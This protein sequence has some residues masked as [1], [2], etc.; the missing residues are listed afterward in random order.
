MDLGKVFIRR[1]TWIRP[2]LQ[3]FSFHQAL[4]PL[5]DH[6][7]IWLEA[8]GQLLNYFGDELLVWEMFALPIMEVS[9]YLGS[10]D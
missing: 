7:D 10:P 2:S 8:V 9:F 6:V 4:D 1:F 3:V 5:L